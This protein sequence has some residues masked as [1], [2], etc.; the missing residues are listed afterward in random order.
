ML[1]ITTYADT[2]IKKNHCIQLLSNYLTTK[3]ITGVVSSTITPPKEFRS[4]EKEFELKIEV[5]NRS[6][7]DLINYIKLNTK[8]TGNRYYFVNGYRFVSETIA[9]LNLELDVCNT[10][11]TELN[12]KIFKNVKIKRQHKDR[13]LLHNQTYYR[14]YDEFDEGLGDVGSEVELNEPMSTDECYVISKQIEDSDSL[15]VCNSTIINQIA[16]NTS[17][18]ITTYTNYVANL[19]ITGS[20]YGGKCI[21]AHCNQSEKLLSIYI[22]FANKTNFTIL[23]NAFLL[24]RDGHNNQYYFYIGYW[25]NNKFLPVNKVEIGTWGDLESST[26]EIQNIT[27]NG[28][29]VLRTTNNLTLSTSIDVG[30]YYDLENIINN[31][32]TYLSGTK[33]STLNIP[34]INY[35]NKTDSQIK[36]I[37]SVPFT[38]STVNSIDNIGVVLDSLISYTTSKDLGSWHYS[39]ALNKGVRERLQSLESKLYGSYVRNHQLVYDTFALPVQPEYYT[40]YSQSISTTLYKPIDMTNDLAI[41]CNTLKQQTLN[42]NVLMCNRNNDI[43]TWT[44]DYL[45]YVRNGYNYDQKSQSL[46]KIKDSIDL[47]SSFATLGVSVAKQ[48]SSGM[49]GIGQ[50]INA[51][52]KVVNQI[53]S[54][55]FS[56]IENSRALEQK[57][58][59]LINTCPTMSGSDN[60]T[61]FKEINGGNVVRYVT[62]KPTDTLL[63]SIWNLFYFQ[64]YA[65]DSF[66]DTF[67]IIKTREYFNFIQADVEK[68]NFY[69][70]KVCH[71][72]IEAFSEGITFEW[73]Y[74]GDWLMNGTLYE[75]WE[76][77]I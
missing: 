30:S 38:P 56:N 36:K 54:S 13:W 45:E 59:G 42:S 27:G 5:L 7:L 73:K 66:V 52:K 60:I 63:N 17:K 69:D 8:E 70:R 3:E 9:L 24:R 16:F 62:T 23:G 58:L 1:T 71:W 46:T 39:K 26:L 19:S 25:S 29:F 55:I 6:N 49:F 53:S 51:G 48:S 15:H 21:F 72:L 35:L 50:S 44:N 47:A 31:F 11:A 43:A 74:N 34:G 28:S 75:N 4:N 14:I 10:Y 32:S 61:L 68:V 41:K 22:N 18:T 77:S 64:G 2:R 37:T 12:S 33:S 57:R 65:D 20:T 67:G 76:T 40:D